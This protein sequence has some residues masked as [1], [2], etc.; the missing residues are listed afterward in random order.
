MGNL[1][2]SLIFRPHPPSY[3]RNR[4]DLHFF[5][6]KHGSKICGIFIDNKADTTI[7]FSHAN[8]EDIG[9]VV[10]FYQYRLRRLGLNLFAYDYSGYG[11]SSGH[12]TE[13]HVYNDVEAA[14]DYLVK[15][16]RV[17]RHSIIAYGR[18][19]GSAASVHIATKKN[20]LGLILQAPLASIHRVKLKL[21]F[22]LPYDSFCNIDKVHMINC[23]ILFIHGTKDKLL[24]Y[25]GTEEMIRRT[26]V[27]TYFMFIEGGGHN[28][29]DSSYGNQVYAALVAFLYVLKNNIRE[30][31]NS[32]Y[33]ISNVNMM[34]LRNMFISNN[35]KNMKERVKEKKRK[36][37]ENGMVSGSAGSVNGRQGNRNESRGSNEVLNS[38]MSNMERWYTDESIFRVYTKDSGYDSSQS[39]SSVLGSAESTMRHIPDNTFYESDTNISIEDLC[40][41]AG[42]KNNLNRSKLYNGKDS[43]A[44]CSSFTKRGWID[45]SDGA[46]GNHRNG[47][48]GV[49]RER[50][51]DGRRIDSKDGR[52]R[53]RMKVC[54][55]YVYNPARRENIS[56]SNMDH[57]SSQCSRSDVYMGSEQDLAQRGNG[58]CMGG[59]SSEKVNSRRSGE[60]RNIYSVDRVPRISQDMK[61]VGS[62][63]VSER[64]SYARSYEQCNNGREETTIRGHRNGEQYS[65]ESRKG[66][67][68]MNPSKAS[69]ASV[70]SND[71]KI[72][73][74][75]RGPFKEERAKVMNE[76][77]RN[78]QSDTI[79]QGSS[80][81][82]EG[83]ATSEHVYSKNYYKKEGNRI[84]K[85]MENKI[86][87]INNQKINRYNEFIYGNQENKMG[88]CPNEIM[89]PVQREVSSASSS[90]LNNLNSLFAY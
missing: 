74:V 34:K 88:D 77:R 87:D 68:N 45:R 38:F 33:D 82:K 69:L 10:R 11:H 35:T 66:G 85:E 1:L 4:H 23:P 18:S 37:E 41:L 70:S 2:N 5:E 73:S 64:G 78:M 72:S 65:S 49:S 26:N 55:S 52:D 3:S 20:L 24:S 40:R 62:S 83:C 25:H 89:E 90:T 22:T 79:K 60:S 36:G 84:R 31:V 28:D 81:V 67:G 63:P 58:T 9:D 32:V 6:T 16:L 30:N 61:S 8:A 54:S 80:V 42:G 19:L 29:L 44:S 57:S 27:N 47:H 75:G 43:G 17:P 56:P 71:S 59:S 14:Y 50:Y 13:A 53:S 12:P 51:P 86:T 7:L 39:L 21:K 48:R 76:S 46:V 15:V